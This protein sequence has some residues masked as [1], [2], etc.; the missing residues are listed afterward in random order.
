MWSQ[1]KKKRKK[2]FSQSGCNRVDGVERDGRIS[3]LADLVF[4]FRL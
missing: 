2:V 4:D 1:T 3:F